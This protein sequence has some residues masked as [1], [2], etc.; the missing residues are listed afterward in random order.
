MNMHQVHG[1]TSQLTGR[2]KQFTGRLLGNHAL[3]SA[4][5]LERSLGSVNAIYGDALARIHRGGGASLAR[6]RAASGS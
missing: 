1:R 6:S 3:E 2:L 4:G 5:R